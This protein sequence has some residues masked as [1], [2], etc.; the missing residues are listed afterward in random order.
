MN[1]GVV[2]RKSEQAK[3]ALDSLLQ[4][5]EMFQE[6]NDNHNITSCYLNIGIY[7]L[8]NHQADEALKYFYLSLNLS[9]EIN[10]ARY[11]CYSLDNI[12]EAYFNKNE[13]DKASKYLR[14]ALEK[15]QATDQKES[16]KTSY[17]LLYQIAEAQEDYKE[18][19]FIFKQHIKVKEDLINMES[20]RQISELKLSH[21]LENKAREAEINYLRNVELKN[22]LD[23]LSIEQERSQSL[24]LNIL[25]QEV[26]EELKEYGKAD[27]KH[28]DE[29]SVMFIDIKDFTQTSELLSPVELVMELD[30]LFRGFDDIIEANK[31][32]KIKTIGD[33]YMCAGGIP[34]IDEN[35]PV[36]IIKAALQILEYTKDLKKLRDALHRPS[37]SVRIGVH[38]G[39]VVAGIV[40]HKKFAYDIWGDTVNTASRIESAGEAGKVNISQATYDL[41]QH[42]FHCQHRGKL[43]MKH[44]ADSEMYFVLSPK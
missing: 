12:G 16:I 33:A 29:V 39:P 20:H 25:P 28:Y 15:A 34:M 3:L 24:L 17:K 19:H 22:A 9:R 26:A 7:F 31:L 18:A 11:E 1:K 5:L 2:L 21:D 44:K 42:D 13:L 30:I 10:D 43:P 40:G 41:I 8:D 27:A 32:E 23:N 35:H 38:T 6:L 14:L 4:A 37:F 36:R